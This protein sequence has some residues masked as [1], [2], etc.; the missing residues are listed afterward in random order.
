MHKQLPSRITYLNMLIEWIFFNKVWFFQQKIIWSNE[1]LVFE[2]NHPK[3]SQAFKRYVVFF[4]HI[5]KY[6]SRTHDILM[7]VVWLQY[8]VLCGH[9]AVCSYIE[10]TKAD[11]ASSKRIPNE[12]V[13]L[14]YLFCK[15]VTY[16]PS[17]LS[18]LT[19]AKNQC[20]CL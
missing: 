20:D 18:S 14:L 16:M 19:T 9:G 5:S 4:V 8:F 2:L 7:N 11:D 17:L 12:R 10:C 3:S 13:Y 6:T 1:R 15:P